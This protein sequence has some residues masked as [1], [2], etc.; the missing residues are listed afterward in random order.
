MKVSLSTYRARAR[1]SLKNQ[2]GINAW[3]VFLSIFIS[4]VIE[5]IFGSVS[6]FSEGSVSQQVLTFV[7]NTFVLF[8]FTYALYY[9]GLFVLRGGKARP[10]MLM[11]IFQKEYYLP[12]LL[13]NLLNTI[14]NWLIGAVVFIPLLL[15]SGLTSYV[16]LVINNGASVT[17]AQS[18]VQ[19]IDVTFI[20]LVLIT[21]IL[22]F[23]LMTIVGGLF[24]FAIWTKMDYP[25]LTIRQCVGHAWFLLKDRLGRYILLQLSFIGWYIIGTIALAIGLLWVM[26]YVNVTIAAFYDEARNEKSEHYFAELEAK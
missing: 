14:V 25:E 9:I 10:G 2:W 6:N 12:M 16:E 4:A 1:E 24:Q 13:L 20:I 23:L 7:L 3:I 17:T 21:T 8:G 15:S 19:S 11:T 18:S 5:S 26:V 22:S